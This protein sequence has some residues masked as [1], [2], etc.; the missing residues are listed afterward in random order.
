MKLDGGLLRYLTREDIRVLT[1]I[2][3]GMKN[4]ELVP[5]S[6]IESIAKL[7]RGGTFKVVTQL[8]KYKLIRHEN[9]QYDGYTL[10]YQG[11]DIL[12]LHT[13]IRRGHL[14]GIGAMI[15]TGKESDIYICQDSEGNEV[16]LKLA[17]LGRTSFR[18]VKSKRD[19]LKHRQKCN[20]LFMSRLAAVREYTFMQ[21]LKGRNFP[22]PTPIDH[23]RHAI[24]MSLVPGYTLTNITEIAHPQKIFDDALNLA[25]RFVENGLVHSD[26][27]E[28]N[29]MVTEDEEVVVIDFPQMVSVDH[30]NAKELFDRDMQCLKDFF[31]GRFGL[32]CDE[33]PQLEHIEVVERLDNVVKAS[34]YARQHFKA[35]E[36]DLFITDGPSRTHDQEGEDEEDV[37]EQIEEGE[38]EIEATDEQLEGLED[39]E[40]EAAEEE[41][42]TEGTE[43]LSERQVSETAQVKLKRP[44]PKQIAMKVKRQYANQRTKRNKVKDRAAIKARQQAAEFQ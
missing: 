30:L 29:L 37:E 25:V 26:F 17:R 32:Q 20:W 39:S 22:V 6:L 3:M 28:F 38:E 21:E 7:K 41:D 23:N 14:R 12:A 1:A 9:H 31:E 5:P 16:V 34:G 4:H 33:L 19:Y 27:N 42:K 24:L 8:L 13:F 35:D 2:E 43:D 15:G 40:E 36:F 11:Y 18:A 44:D 10:T